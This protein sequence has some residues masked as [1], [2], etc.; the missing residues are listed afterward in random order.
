MEKASAVWNE[1][2]IIKRCPR[3]KNMEEIINQITLEILA[4]PLMQHVYI[5]EYIVVEMETDII[6]GNVRVVGIFP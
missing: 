4:N 2:K 6:M 1:K 5:Y 3:E